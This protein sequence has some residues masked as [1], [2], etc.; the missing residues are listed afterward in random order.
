MANPYVGSNIA[1][2]NSPTLGVDKATYTAIFDLLCQVLDEH[3]HSSNKGLQ[4]DTAGLANLSVTTAKIAAAAVD[5]TK[6]ATSIAGAGLTGGAGTALSVVVD[7]T[8]I[9]ITTDTLNVKA[10]GIGTTQLADLGVTT[11][12]LADNAVTL[13]K[14]ATAI[15]DYFVPIGTVLDFGGATAPTGYLL[16]YG[17]AISRTT[18]S[19]LFGIIGGAFGIGDGST[20]FNLP[21]CR[22]RVAAGKDNMGGSAASRI[23]FAGSGIDGTGMGATGGDEEITLV[24]GQMPSHTHVAASHTHTVTD[25]GHTHSYHDILSGAGGTPQISAGGAVGGTTTDSSP[26]S[27]NLSATGT[28]VTLN[29]TGNDAAHVNV[30][31]TIIFNKIIRAL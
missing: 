27:A 1:N 16:C 13:G 2:C 6:L 23:T 9:E 28:V 20:T 21:D 11:G 12:K 24:E 29:D 15:S 26:G 5:A 8:T 7:G 4:V 10:G 19:V 22:G 3:D 18:Y 31:P 14:L 17:Q 30:Q 25:S